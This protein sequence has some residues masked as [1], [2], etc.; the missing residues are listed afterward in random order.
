MNFFVENKGKKFLRINED[1]DLRFID[2]PLPAAPMFNRIE[3]HHLPREKQ[4]FVYQKIPD[5]LMK[6]VEADKEDESNE[7]T[8][9]QIHKH[10]RENQR[11][12]KDEIAW[13]KLQWHRLEYGHHFFNNGDHTYL[14]GYHYVYNNFWNINSARKDKLPEYRLRDQVYWHTTSW[15]ERQPNIVGML[16]F[17]YR[18]EGATSKACCQNYFKNIKLHRQIHGIQSLSDDHVQKLWKENMLAAWKD[19]P[20]FFKPEHAGSDNPKEFN[21]QPPS[22]RGSASGTMG[23]VRRGLAGLIG[24]QTSPI[25]KYDSWTL[26]FYHCDEFGK[27]SVQAPVDSFDRWMRILPAMKHGSMKRGYAL[28]TSTIGDESQNEGGIEYAKKFYETSKY[29][30]LDQ[31]GFTIS[32]LW[33]LFIPSHVNQTGFND[34]YGN[35]LQNVGPEGKLNSEGRRVYRTALDW[36][37]EN[38]RRLE[39]KKQWNALNEETRKYPIYFRECFRASGATALF[40]QEILNQVITHLER[41]D[42]FNKILT[43]GHLRWVPGKKYQEVEFISDFERLQKPNQ[44][45]DLAG[46]G[47]WYFSQQPREGLA[48]KMVFDS[49]FPRMFAGCN[50]F[51]PTYAGEYT[52]STDPVK[53]E[54]TLSGN[55]SK[56]AITVKRSHND[57]T[58]TPGNEHNWKTD[59]FVADYITEV[60]NLDACSEQVLMA[61]IYFSTMLYGEN[62]VGEANNFFK[63][64]GFQGFVQ[65]RITDKGVID[66]NPGFS[67]QGNSKQVMFGKMSN[68]IDR[69]GLYEKHVRILKQARDIMTATDL[70]S[71]DSLASAMGNFMAEEQNY[72]KFVRKSIPNGNKNLIDYLQ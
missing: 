40:N 62:N 39:E 66:P 16:Y 10:I 12:Y 49:R 52:V 20:F 71:N 46:D 51:V 67:T 43:R 35:P 29:W 32:G 60:D 59:C 47:P 25:D 56:W 50:G 37:T 38:R 41:G 8:L 54:E 72:A 24:Y 9:K 23:T 28:F 22:K 53:Y 48:N 13:M 1:P 57:V 31:D 61:C 45:P 36:I 65:H 7:Y 34:P 68:Y 3:N 17:K 19:L 27:K 21:F 63:R 6:F 30:E 26:D 33:P 4:M 15:M 14:D 42:V 5:K 55:K 70:K 69:R 11:E 18:Q 64:N 44:Y 2:I 58:D